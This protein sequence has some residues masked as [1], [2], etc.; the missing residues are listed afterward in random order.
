MEKKKK[1]KKGDDIYL[2]FWPTVFF[3]ST[4]SSSLCF[5]IFFTSLFI[6]VSWLVNNNLEKMLEFI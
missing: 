5:Y 1:E 3:N 6:F 2:R 4:I